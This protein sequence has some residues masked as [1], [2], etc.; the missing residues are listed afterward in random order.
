MTK[1]GS[2]PEKAISE[3]ASDLNVSSRREGTLSTYSSAWNKWVSCCV[4]QNTDPV[5]CNVNWIVD[6]LAFLFE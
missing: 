3:R 4:E 5:R 2:A 6:F 1:A